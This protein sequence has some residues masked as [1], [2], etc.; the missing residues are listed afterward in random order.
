MLHGAE[1]RSLPEVRD[2]RALVREL[3]IDRRQHAGHVL[4]REAVKAV[5]AN[6]CVLEAAGDC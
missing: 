1:A 5:L 6:A 3:G 4:V 2:H